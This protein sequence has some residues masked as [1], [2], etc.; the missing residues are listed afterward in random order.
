MSDERERDQE[1][2]PKQKI[3]NHER[4]EKLQDNM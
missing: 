2:F 3:Q 4:T 1:G